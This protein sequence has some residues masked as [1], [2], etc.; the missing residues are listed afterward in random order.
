[1]TRI[2]RYAA[3]GGDWGTA[4]SA[5]MG[6]RAPAGLAGFY[7][8]LAQML[9]AINDF[10]GAQRDV[11][12]AESL[13]REVRETVTL[14]PARISGAGYLPRSPAAGLRGRS[15]SRYSAAHTDGCYA[16]KMG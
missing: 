15:R 8:R 7:V 4:I 13:P 9:S 10:L 11:E 1:M 16:A 14:R 6:R 12:R 3:H 5:A 2:H